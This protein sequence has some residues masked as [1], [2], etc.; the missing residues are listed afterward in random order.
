MIQSSPRQRSNTVTDTSERITLHRTEEYEVTTE[1]NDTVRVHEFEGTWL[2]L[3]DGDGNT[4]LRI[5]NLSDQQLAAL[6][7]EIGRKLGIP[8]SVTMEHLRKL[9]QHLGAVLGSGS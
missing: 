7:S 8:S 4:I 9:H 2:L 3:E 5:Y 1:P 6:Y